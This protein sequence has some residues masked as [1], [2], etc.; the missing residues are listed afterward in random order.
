MAVSELHRRRGDPPRLRRE[1]KLELTTAPWSQTTATGI[2]EGFRSPKPGRVA[3]GGA[4][5]KGHATPCVILRQPGPPRL[6]GHQP[7]RLPPP[8]RQS[9]QILQPSDSYWAPGADRMPFLL[10]WSRWQLCSAI[11]RW[12][13]LASAG[14]RLMQACKLSPDVP[15]AGLPC[16]A[17]ALVP[18][19]SE[20]PEEVG[21]SS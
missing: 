2:P 20:A 12:P 17:E 19:P 3:T 9:S 16:G 8:R 14:I 4:G 5:A 13:A 10:S 15:E 18:P 1:G 21:V 11:M 6:G 7:E